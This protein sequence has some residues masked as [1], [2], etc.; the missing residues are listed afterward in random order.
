M[1]NRFSDAVDY[2][3]YHLANKSYKYDDRLAKSVVR[4]VNRLQIHMKTNMCVTVHL[5][6]IIRLLST[7]ELACGRDGIHEGAAIWLLP[8]FIKGRLL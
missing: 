2:H 4:W 3:N 1:I 6:S 5:K 8:S 7:F